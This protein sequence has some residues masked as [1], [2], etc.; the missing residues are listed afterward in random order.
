MVFVL[1]VI[2]DVFSFFRQV[3]AGRLGLVA[4]DIVRIHVLCCA[5]STGYASGQ[6]LCPPNRTFARRGAAKT[7]G[8]MGCVD[9]CPCAIIAIVAIYMVLLSF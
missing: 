3:W 2:L 9:K 5:V 1:P 8:G 6:I 7:I 4:D